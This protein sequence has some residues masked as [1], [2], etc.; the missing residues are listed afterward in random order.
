MGGNCAAKLLLYSV[1]YNDFKQLQSNNDWNGVENM[2]SEIAINLENAGADC[3]M[4]CCNTGHIVADELKKKISIPFLHIADETTKEI[5][6]HNFKKVG[7]LGTAFTM[8]NS[9][10]INRLAHAGIETLLP[11]TT[12]CN[13]IHAAIMNELA[14][15]FLS[16]AST[17]MFQSVIQ[18]LK[19]QGAEAVVF[20]CT[21]IGMFISQSDC[22]LP[23]FDTTIIHT[24]A[25]V[26]F[27]ISLQ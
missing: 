20:G 13:L 23:I 5:L 19:K 18:K 8:K 6:K 15:G 26:D 3:I 4:I 2:L 11:N 25:A 10:F 9:F 16:N 14:K 17:K 22:V 7:L 12:E 24:N 21:E 27:A 1:N